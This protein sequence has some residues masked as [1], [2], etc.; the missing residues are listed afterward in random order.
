MLYGIFRIIFWGIVFS[1]AYFLLM[2]KTKTARRKIVAILTLV[3]C[4]IFGSVSA[5]L[6]AENLFIKF[7][8]PEDVFSYYQVGK[9]DDVLYGNNSSL[10]IYSNGNN[11]G[12]HF[13]VPKSAK[14]YK[15]PSLFSVKKI[16]S[17]IDR[18]G[19]FNVYNVLGTN[20]YYF[21]GTIISKENVI[22][23]IDSN[24][25]EVKNITLEM[26]NTDTKTVLVYSFV[27]NFT[28]EYFI[29][30]NGEPITVSY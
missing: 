29:V 24:N 7:K 27:E 2:K 22:N 23:I 5:L 18:D 10:I 6:P 1:L 3:L 14:R 30:I 15:I 9:V 16:S 25:N 4:M 12:G 19:S 20:D 11:S 21:I 8:T 26:G 28:N 13:I 17:K